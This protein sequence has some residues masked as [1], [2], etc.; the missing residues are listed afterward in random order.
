M[1][2]KAQSNSNELVK[3]KEE[4]IV[5][6]AWFFDGEGCVTLHKKI[7]LYSE[8][9]TYELMLQVAGTHY[10]SIKK[11]K[12]LWNVGT[13]NQHKENRI[14][15]RKDSYHWVC[16]GH[17]AFFILSCIYKYSITKKNDI[18]IG[19]T[20]QEWKSRESDIYG[21]GNRPE[22]SYIR[23]NLFKQLLTQSHDDFEKDVKSELAN[24]F[25]KEL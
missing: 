22:D 13:V 14:S 8:I 11:V 19:I 16:Y 21:K 24:I 4:D 6:F 5:W 9:P 3:P 1:E 15:N 23:E 20:Y 18:L 25:N 7:R 2:L 12:E 17:N 10:P